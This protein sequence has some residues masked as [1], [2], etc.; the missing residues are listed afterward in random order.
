MIW[1]SSQ[2]QH[3]L[4][5]CRDIVGAD[6]ARKIWSLGNS[7]PAALCSPRPLSCGRGQAARLLGFFATA[8][9]RG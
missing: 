5:L 6:W 7:L 1:M 2:Q 9:T 8:V 4:R 3:R